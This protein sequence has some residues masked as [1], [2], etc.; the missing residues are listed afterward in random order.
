MAQYEKTVVDRNTIKIAVSPK[1]TNDIFC[2]IHLSSDESF[3]PDHTSVEYEIKEELGEN[4]T[5]DQAKKLKKA[6]SKYLTIAHAG[7]AMLPKEQQRTLTLQFLQRFIN[8]KGGVVNLPYSKI[9]DDPGFRGEFVSVFQDGLK[10]VNERA[11]HFLSEP[12]KTTYSENFPEREEKY[13]G[14]GLD[15]GFVGDLSTSIGGARIT[16]TRD[17]NGTIYGSIS[18]TYTFMDDPNKNLTVAFTHNA[19][20]DGF[21]LLQYLGWNGPSAVT[22]KWMADLEKYGIA[23]KFIVRVNWSKKKNEKEWK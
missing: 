21:P 2:E 19:Q 15:V 9:K 12:Q 11:A 10:S 6:I 22:D 3:S 8:C 16:Y 13:S 18:D 20:H 23:K 5:L 1:Q 17:S 7:N 14:T 4:L